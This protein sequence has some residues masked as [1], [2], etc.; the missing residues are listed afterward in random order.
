MFR[1]ETEEE[2]ESTAL[3]AL[4]YIFI[5]LGN[6]NGDIIILRAFIALMRKY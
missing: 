6:F 4:N 3:H 5:S 2:F 1:K